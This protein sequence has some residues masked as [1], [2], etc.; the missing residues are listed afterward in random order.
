MVYGKYELPLRMNIVRPATTAEDSP[1]V[2]CIHGGG[3][4]AGNKND[5]QEMCNGLAAL[6]YVAVS[7][8][9]RFAPTFRYPSQIDD[10][11]ACMKYLRA[12]AKELKINPNKIGAIG[13]SAGGHLALLLAETDEDGDFIKPGKS[14]VLRAAAS[15]AGP[16]DLCAKLPPAAIPIAENLIGTPISKD[17]EAHKQASPINHLSK[18]CAPLLL[19]HGDKDELVPYDQAT[20]MIEAC[21]KAGVEAELFTIHNGTHGGGGDK[22]ERDASIKKLADFLDKYLKH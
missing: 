18:S 6:G 7:V 8:E 1:L 15:L 4:A 22:A 10:V 20:S 11:R 9:Y 21:K 2:I 3:W 17:P 14:S 16:T 13:G 5:M 19:I 12:H